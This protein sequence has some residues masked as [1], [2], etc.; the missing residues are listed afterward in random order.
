MK[1]L[2]FNLSGK[3]AFFKKPDVNQ[4]AYYTYNNI[5]K[6][7]LL[8]V[9]GAIIGLKGYNQQKK[10]KY[11]EFYE[12]LKDFKISIVPKKKYFDKKIQIFNNTVGYASQEANNIL[13]VREQWLEE[14]EWDIY[15]L[16]NQ[17]Q[18]Y[19]KIENFLLNK[20]TEYIPY[21]G[22]NDHSADIKDVEKVNLSKEEKINH[23]DSIFLEKICELG[24]YPYDD[25]NE[26][27][28]KEKQP[29]KLNE[30]YNFY[31]FE[32]TIY[33]NLEIEKLKNGSDV[34]TDGEKILYFF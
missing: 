25:E 2:K 24:I 22:K 4:Y 3:T 19:E 11:P 26:Y 34:Y 20:K 14:P 33:T 28:L 29:I 7:A 27:I 9:F 15:I 30:M 16:E 31:E 8:G 23:I 10:E 17:S 13:N 1:A 12:K 18:E 21:L 5:H 32:N 6:I